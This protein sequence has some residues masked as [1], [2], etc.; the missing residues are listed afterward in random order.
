MVPPSAGDCFESSM[1]TG[2]RSATRAL[3]SASSK[4]ETAPFS[5][6][7]LPSTTTVSTSRPVNPARGGEHR[8]IDRL[9]VPIARI[10]DHDVCALA[11]FEAAYVIGHAECTGTPQSCHFEKILERQGRAVV[12]RRAVVALHGDERHP[13]RFEEV[14]AAGGGPVCAES[15]ADSTALHLWHLRRSD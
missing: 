1:I 12:P 15:D 13:D 8:V 6:T 14:Q 3:S 9:Q 4:V 7:I 2:H 5:T 10:G 11:D